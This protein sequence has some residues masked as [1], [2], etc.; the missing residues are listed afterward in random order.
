MKKVHVFLLA[1]FSVI[2]VFQPESFCLASKSA[3]FR[4]FFRDTP[5]ELLADLSIEEKVGQI[6]I[7]GFTGEALDRDYEAWMAAGSLGN[8]K[9]FLRNVRSHA[10]LRALSDRITQLTLSSPHGIPPFIATDMEGGTVN[11]V[12]YRGIYLAPAAGLLGAAAR[13]EYSHQA[14]R[15]I[16]LTLYNHGVNMNFAPCVDVLTNPLNRVIGT[17]SYS[18]DPEIVSSMATAFIE[19][20]RKLGILTTAKHFPG[21]GMTTYD[22]HLFSAT[23]DM[24]QSELHDV[25]AY[26]YHQ[27]IEQRKLDGIMVSH[28]T[29]GR[30]D[31]IYPASLSSKVINGYLRNDLGYRGIVVTDDLEMQG[32][33]T[34]AG[35]IVK[36]F[37]LAFRAGNDLFLISHTKETQRRLLHEA[38]ALVENGIL[39]EAEL[40]K[41][42]LRILEAKHR[43]LIRFYGAHGGTAVQQKLLQQSINENIRL[44]ADGIVL[45]SSQIDASPPSFFRE[46]EKEEKK[47]LILSPSKSFGIRAKRYL[48][49]WDIIDIGFYP[50]KYENRERVDQTREKLKE[51]DVI[52]LGFA[53]ERHIPWARACMKADVPFAIL[54]YDNPQYAQRFAPHALFIVTCFAPYN[55]GAD[56]LFVSVFETGRFSHNFPYSF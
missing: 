49:F 16:A 37:L 54:S 31:P 40:D 3:E 50:D 2:F 13:I 15:L 6:L 26:P 11:H 35:D 20:H 55:P 4:Y 24:E 17:R 52:V 51:Y 33:Q 43:Y 5:E 48:P 22:S 1:V 10:Q 12:R 56:A 38:V 30:I 25:H 27:L 34:Y 41:K 53:N 36:A 47:G 39:S 45:M 7:F 28:I 42:V 14:A 46:M 29:Y 8:I 23:V 9:I 19:E 21:H 32:T 18:S 44:T